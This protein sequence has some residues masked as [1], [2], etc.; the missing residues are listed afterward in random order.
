MEGQMS[1]R[2]QQ[3]SHKNRLKEQCYKFPFQ[4]DFQETGKK[5]KIMKIKGNV[6]FCEEKNIT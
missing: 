2:C 3:N 1:T 5:T 6:L 4:K